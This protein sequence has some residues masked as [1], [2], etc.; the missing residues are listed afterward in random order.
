MIKYLGENDLKLKDT[1][2]GGKEGFWT[3]RMSQGNAYWLNYDKVL[4][5]FNELIEAVN[6]L[7]KKVNE[8]AQS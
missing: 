7:E 4:N 6:Q 8:M 5:K 1:N 2:S 3:L